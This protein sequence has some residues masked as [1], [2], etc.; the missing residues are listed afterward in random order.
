[1]DIIINK[2]A[3]GQ[4]YLEY[5]TLGGVI[6]LYFMAGPT[7]VAVAQQYSETVG[8]SVMMPYWSLGFHQC[9][10]GMQDVFVSPPFDPPFSN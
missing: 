3:L 2:T 5:N 1:M 6:D 10:Y 9:R 8:K 7:P 4:Q